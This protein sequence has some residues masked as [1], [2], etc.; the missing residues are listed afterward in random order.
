MLGLSGVS[1]DNALLSREGH[2]VATLRA[3]SLPRAASCLA[4]TDGGSVR[5]A[6][7]NYL[8]LQLATTSAHPLT[9][10]GSLPFGRMTD[11]LRSHS[12]IAD[13]GAARVLRQQCNRLLTVAASSS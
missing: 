9:G 4:G 7:A 2:P 3:P 10:G 6:P 12:A 13:I 11:A 1:R 8:L 5:P